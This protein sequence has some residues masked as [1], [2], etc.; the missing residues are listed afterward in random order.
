MTEAVEIRAADGVVLRGQVRRAGPSWTILVHEPGEDLDAW[1]P[2]PAVLAARGFT[3]LTHDLRGHGG[4]D[5]TAAHDLDSDDLASVV[6]LAR[7]LGAGDIYV[8]AAGASTGPALEAAGASGCAAFV[9]LGPLGHALERTPALPKLA[10]VASRD[11]AQEAASAQLALAPGGCVVVRLPVAE[12]GT[13]LLRGAWASNVHE[14]VAGFVR[15]R[16]LSRPGPK[17]GA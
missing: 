1:K 5:G 6:S 14:Y 13:A 16:G 15:D 12:R 10:I 8:G 2:L 3:V 7:D 4:S 11:P 17:V 9:A